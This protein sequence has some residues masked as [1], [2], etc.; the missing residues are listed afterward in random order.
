MKANHLPR[1]GKK[2]CAFTLIELLVIL[3]IIAILA[4]LLLPALS[5]G[6]HKAV[7]IACVSKQR[8]LWLWDAFFMDDH[9]GMW[10]RHCTRGAVWPGRWYSQ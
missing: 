1:Q 8:Q 10:A 9:D 7:Q 5:K 6:R 2:N 4:S 3:A